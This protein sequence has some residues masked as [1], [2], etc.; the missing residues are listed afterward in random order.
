MDIYC[1]GMLTKILQLMGLKFAVN[2]AAQKQQFLQ[3]GYIAEY[4]EVLGFITT[5]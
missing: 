5:D 1:L 3:E 2:A 4:A